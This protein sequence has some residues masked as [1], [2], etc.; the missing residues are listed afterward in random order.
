V[1]GQR[2]AGA[3]YVLR[4]SVYAL[5]TNAV[6]QV[7]VVRTAQGV[8]LPG[9]GIEMGETAEQAVQREVLEEC[10]LAIRLLS[11]L[12]RAL[13]LVYSQAELTYFEK[14][15]TFFAA[16]V[17]EQRSGPSEKDHE[18]FGLSLMRRHCFSLTRAIAGRCVGVPHNVTVQR[19]GRSRCS[20]SGR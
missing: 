20:R 9:G 13:Q 4:P 2:V 8:F 7:A 11:R 18:V 1:F 5:I 19:T 14:V 12:P 15:S 3:S 10:G 17:E 6:G 16:V